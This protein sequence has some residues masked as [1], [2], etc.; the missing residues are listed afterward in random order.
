MVINGLLKWPGYENTRFASVLARIALSCFFAAVIYLNCSLRA[1]I[2]WFLVILFGYWA[3]MELVP[4]P[5]YGAGVLTAD[6]NLSAYIDRLFLPGKLHRK[7]YDP[8][9]IFSTIPAICTAL[10]GVFTGQLLRWQ[11]ASWNMKRKGLALAVAAFV[12]MGCGL[13]WNTVFPI[14]KIMWTSAFVLYAG[15]WS[16]LFFAV[17]YL[18]IDVA[19]Y[20]KWSLPFVWIGTNS[21]LIY[22]A[23]HGLIDFESTARYLVG[24]FISMAGRLWQPVW[25][26]VAVMFLQLALLYF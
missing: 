10:L 25:L 5:G 1:Q 8:E 14:N 6:G 13:L 16:V 2:T 23:S 15:G 3:A 9:G 17:F 24:G 22:M 20:K 26:A 18:V 4:V 12:L 21:I 19:G 7:V 11:H